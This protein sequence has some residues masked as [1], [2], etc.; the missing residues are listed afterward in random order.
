MF[1]DWE[2]GEIVTRIDVEA[3]NVGLQF[4]FLLF[5]LIQHFLS[6]RGFWSGTGSLVAITA[7]A[8][9]AFSTS[10]DSIEM[11]TTQNLK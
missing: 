11:P 8:L 10:F 6:R 1:Q 9:K 4:L 5:S 7:E 2:S 3:K